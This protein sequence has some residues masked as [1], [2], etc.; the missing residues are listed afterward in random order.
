[1]KKIIVMMALI[2]SSVSAQANEVSTKVIKAPFLATYF[3]SYTIGTTTSGINICKE[4]QQ[5]IADGEEY[6]LT[7][8]LTPYLKQSVEALQAQS[9]DLSTDEAV[10]LLIE[11]A[12]SILE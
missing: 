10:D 12:V 5:I 9:D 2:I 1:M 3:V 4:A 7:G 8:E 11:K 6:T